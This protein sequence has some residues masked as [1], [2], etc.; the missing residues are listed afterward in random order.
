MMESLEY[1][2][3]FV[4]LIR[5][6]YVFLSGLVIAFG[7]S[8][9]P[10]GPVVQ[11][12]AVIGS[13]FGGFFRL[14]QGQLETLV[15]AG[16]AAGVAA[17]FRSPA[18]AAF[19]AVE[20]LG[21]RFD[22]GLVAISVAAWIG[23]CLRLATLADARPFVPASPLA[24]LPTFTLVV[25]IPLMGLAAACAGCGFIWLFNRTRLAF[26]QR[27]PLVVRLAVGGAIV[28]LMG[29][30]FP[31]VMSTGWST[32]KL[33]LEGQMGFS[34]LVLLFAL[35]MVATSVTFASGAVG[36]LFSPILVIGSLFGGVFAYGVRS[37]I[38]W[39][40][41][42]PELFVLLGMVAMFGSVAK[43]YWS[44]LLVVSDLSGSYHE[45]LL[46]G[47]I[48]G[49]ISYLISSGINQHS[50]FGLPLAAVHLEPAAGEA[51]A[52]SA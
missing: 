1:R 2:Q 23:Y 32:I 45:L 11:L 52:A 4:P 22:R 27:W 7:G 49:G 40:V 3:S 12:G 42:Q 20:V 24:S 36:G 30:W 5:V 41:P 39:A 18:G 38:P 47:L 51:R 35:K 33:G 10:S 28:G 8:V 29:I 16:A 37:V 46:P 6:F 34:L 26:P 9:G 15:R 50:I 31:Q 44:G 21:A 13:K 48:A 25:I 14:T 43:A 17:A 19:L